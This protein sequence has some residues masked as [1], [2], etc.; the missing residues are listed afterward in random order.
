[1][2][3]SLSSRFSLRNEKEMQATSSCLHPLTIKHAQLSFLTPTHLGGL[4][5][6]GTVGLQIRAPISIGFSVAPLITCLVSS[7]FHLTNRRKNRPPAWTWRQWD[8]KARFGCLLP[9]APRQEHTERSQTT[10][11]WLDSPCGPL[12][13]ESTQTCNVNVHSCNPELLRVFIV[14]YLKADCKTFWWKGPKRITTW[15]CRPK[16]SI[17]GLKSKTSTVIKCNHSL[18]LTLDISGVHHYL[19]TP[20]RSCYSTWFGDIVCRDCD[21]LQPVVQPLSW[22][23]PIHQRVLVVPG[24]GPI[25]TTLNRGHGQGFWSLKLGQALSCFRTLSANS[26]F[27]K[28][29]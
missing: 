22:N 4:W 19:F 3:L 23:L 24:S 10:K 7:W 18:I 11:V 8:H 15:W 6:T 9:G 12:R 21:C 26:R 29:R 1:M 5:E 20:R 28:K 25:Q 16:S 13:F 2:T 27:I 14:Q 17:F